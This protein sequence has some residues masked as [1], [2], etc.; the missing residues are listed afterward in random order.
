MAEDGSVTLAGY[1]VPMHG[2]GYADAEFR[3]RRDRRADL[4]ACRPAGLRREQA[5][6]ISSD[7]SSPA[8][9]FIFGTLLDAEDRKLTPSALPPASRNRARRVAPYRRQPRP[10]IQPQLH[11]RRVY[12]CHRRPQSVARDAIEN[13]A[14]S[15]QIIA[16]SFCRAGLDRGTNAR[17]RAAPRLPILWRGRAHGP[18]FST[19]AF[20]RYVGFT[21]KQ[22]FLAGLVSLWGRL[23]LIAW[24]SPTRSERLLRRSFALYLAPQVIDKMLASNKL[25]ALGGE[26]RDVTVFFSDLVG[27]SSIAEKMA[28]AELVAFINEYLSAMTDIIESN[29][30]YSTNISA[31]SL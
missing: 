11:R 1:R 30:G 2:A 3:R 26:T 27:F 4:F 10:R 17:C 25:P 8:R 20:A 21:A 9:S 29:G 23:S 5:M 18:V 7:A 19:L 28:P 13:S 16:I 14:G 24:L 31:T 12:S 15:G 22:P 6:R